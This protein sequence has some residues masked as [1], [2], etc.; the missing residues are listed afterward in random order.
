MTTES[1]LAQTPQ[2]VSRQELDAHLRSLLSPHLFKDYGP[3]GLQ[4]EG[5]G[6]IRKIVSG[7]TA[8]LSLIEAARAAGAD[9]LIVHH[10]LFFKGVDYQPVGWMGKRIRTLIQGDLNLWAYH[11]PLDAHPQLGNNAQLG[12][13]LGLTPV[14]QFGEQNLGLIGHTPQA[15]P[16]LQWV[17]QLEQL[18][19]RQATVV[20]EAQ[21]P[22]KKIAWCTGGAQSYFQAAIDA[23]A[24]VFL[25]GEISEYCAHMAHETGVAYIAAGHHATERYGIQALGEHLAQHWGLAHQFIDIPNPA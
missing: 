2:G 24:D 8:S 1:S 16:L 21:K 10:G 5:G 7:V 19:Q 6:H 20:G 25:T 22:V 13:K 4:V 23:G 12:Q 18:L 15:L 14:G 11:L 17:A 9:A 3:N